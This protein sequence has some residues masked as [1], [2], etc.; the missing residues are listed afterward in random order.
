ML[1]VLQDGSH[2]LHAA[3]EHVHSVPDV[4]HIGC[5]LR[6]AGL[7]V[8]PRPARRR[9]GR[10][11]GA[12]VPMA[13]QPAILLQ[14]MRS[15][16]QRRLESGDKTLKSHFVLQRAISQAGKQ[17][18]LWLQGTC[19]PNHSSGQH[20]EGQHISGTEREVH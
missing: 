16:K 3:G 1:Q 4:V 12:G 5:Q 18:L 11:I 2:L 7:R 10:A 8:V 6:H 9:V 20:S 14:H 19:G 13:I 15:W 17:F